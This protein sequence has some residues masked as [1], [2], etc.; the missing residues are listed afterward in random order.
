MTDVVG[1]RHE[2]R[3]VVDPVSCGFNGNKVPRLA[4]QNEHAGLNAH[5]RLESVGVQIDAGQNS[6][7]TEN[8]LADVPEAGRPEN[9]VRQ[10]DR[11]PA[12][13]RLKKFDTALDKEDFWWLRLLN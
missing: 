8:P 1:H 9:S 7:I 10:N 5:V 12:S 6:G 4:L 3:I 2:Y 11:R 13:P